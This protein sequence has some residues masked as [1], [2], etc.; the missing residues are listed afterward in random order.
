MAFLFFVNCQQKAQLMPLIRKGLFLSVLSLLILPA[1]HAQKTIV[2]GKVT[3]SSG[4]P[5]PSASVRIK[6]AQ[7]GTST[8]TL[9]SFSLRVQM[10][11]SLIIS[12]VGFNDTTVLAGGHTALAI[13]LLQTSGSLHEAL[14]TS[15]PSAANTPDPLEAVKNEVI[16][17]TFQDWVRTAQFSNGQIQGSYIT[18][19]VGGAMK[20]V[21]VSTSGFGA[22]NTLNQGTMLPVLKHQ[23]DTKGSRYLLKDFAHGLI[24]DNT[25][26]FIAD[27]LNLMNYD[28]IDGQLMIGLG[29]KNYLEVDKEKVVAFAF[30]TPD[31]SFIFLNVPVLSKVNYFMLIATGPRYSV[32]KSVRTKFTKAN[33]ISNGLTESGNNY[34][35]YVDTQTYFWVAGKG[36]AG[37]LELKKK[38]IREVFA[39]EK[40]KLDDF[41]AHHK[42][43]D[44]D[45]AFLKKLIFYLNQ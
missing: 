10:G 16:A 21:A 1:L 31:T 19:G 41:F 14:V 35:E 2:T 4:R 26:K 11:D 36:N 34:D 9:G 15:A 22:L 44:I 38:S 39:A 32:Y 27:S 28:K 45:D 7:T 8:D 25:G 43:D 29:Q 6:S 3:D 40:A 23:E 12:A 30:K 17:G 18:T 42:Y 20:M 33:Y 13:V 24:V 37:V 5:V